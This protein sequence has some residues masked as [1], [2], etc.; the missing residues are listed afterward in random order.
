MKRTIKFRKKRLSPDF[1]VYDPITAQSY[2]TTISDHDI[3][4]VTFEVA[5]EYRASVVEVKIRDDDAILRRKVV[6][7]VSEQE[8]LWFDMVDNFLGRMSKYIEKVQWW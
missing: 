1:I 3:S 2:Y 5:R 8:H 6:F 4:K 7:D